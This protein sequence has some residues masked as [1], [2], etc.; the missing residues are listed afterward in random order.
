MGDPR[1]VPGGE[2]EDGEGACEESGDGVPTLR[3]PDIPELVPEERE[4]T[5]VG[6]IVASRLVVGV[7]AMVMSRRDADR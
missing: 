1:G 6:A 5:G 3:N 4:A 2:V 7:E